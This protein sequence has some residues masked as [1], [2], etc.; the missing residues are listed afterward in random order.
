MA[1]R[2]SSKGKGKRK[3]DEDSEAARLQQARQ[4]KRS[5]FAWLAKFLSRG[6]PSKKELVDKNILK[7]KYLLIRRAL[8]S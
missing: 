5:K 2:S 3:D 1:L 4:K 7:G 6:R 8:H